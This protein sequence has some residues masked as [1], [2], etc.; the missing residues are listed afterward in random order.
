MPI[1]VPSGIT[2][3]TK[4]AFRMT[5]EKAAAAAAAASAAPATAAATIRKQ[6]IITIIIIIIYRAESWNQR[7]AEKSGTEGLQLVSENDSRNHKAKVQGPPLNLSQATNTFMITM[8]KII[9]I[10][11]LG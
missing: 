10:I 3:T 2:V 11:T 6:I 4:K 7:S 1:I 5:T 8:I 9:I